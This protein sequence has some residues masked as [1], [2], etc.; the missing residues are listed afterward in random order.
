MPICQS[1]ASTQELG[2]EDRA[3]QRSYCQHAPGHGVKVLPY[4]HLC[5]L[6]VGQCPLVTLLPGFSFLSPL[7]IPKVPALCLPP[8]NAGSTGR[9]EH[10][11][12]PCP[13]PCSDLRGSNTAL[14]TEFSL[15][16]PPYNHRLHIHGRKNDRRQ[17]T[18]STLKIPHT[19][20]LLCLF[21]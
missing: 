7:P 10:R 1:T 3:E 16:A 8:S 15:P 9:G 18:F 12:L 14:P 4:S 17:P 21:H 11:K 6:T 20:T 2:R 5:A 13:G 19:L